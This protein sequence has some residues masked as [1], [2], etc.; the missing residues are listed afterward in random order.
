M[1]G[2][3]KTVF[4][5]GFP[6]LGCYYINGRDLWNKFCCVPYPEFGAGGYGRLFFAFLGRGYCTLSLYLF[7]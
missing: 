1:S 4:C 7:K 3:E 5:Q 2:A 6:A